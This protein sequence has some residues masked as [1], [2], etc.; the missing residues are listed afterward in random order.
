MVLGFMMLSVDGV[1]VF[2]GIYDVTIN[3]ISSINIIN[4][5]MSCSISIFGSAAY[6]AKFDL[7]LF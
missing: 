3:T 6:V 7:F 2:N 4:A 5:S 1:D